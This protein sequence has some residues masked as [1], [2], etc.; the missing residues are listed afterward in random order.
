MCLRCESVGLLWRWVRHGIVVNVLLVSD[1]AAPWRVGGVVVV[2][3]AARGTSGAGLGSGDL[4]RR[5]D[6]GGISKGLSF[7]IYFFNWN[8]GTFDGNSIPT[9]LGPLRRLSI[10]R[11]TFNGLV[12][13]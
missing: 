9:H 11:L 2:I 6:G 13:V 8:F 10:S 3:T 7:V 12:G 1:I 4:T 5:V